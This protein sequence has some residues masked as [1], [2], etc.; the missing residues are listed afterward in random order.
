MRRMALA[1]T[2]LLGLATAAAAQITITAPPAGTTTVGPAD[3]YATRAFQDPWDMNEYTDLGWLTLG[4]DQ[5]AAN[6]SNISVSGGVFSANPT[7]G[8]P[9]FWLLDTF[10]PG[11]A[12]LGKVGRNFPIDASK[13]RD[14]RD[15]DAAREPAGSNV[16]AFGDADPLEQQHDLRH[17]AERRPADEQCGSHLRRRDGQSRRL[18][19]LRHR[20]RRRSAPRPDPA[21]RGA[22]TRC[23]STRPS[24]RTRARSSWTGRASC[25][26]TTRTSSGRSSGPAPPRWTSSSTTTRTRPTATWARSPAGPLAALSPSTWAG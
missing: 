7:N 24:T 5:P 26:S 18:E 13:Y 6:L 14:A 25:R 23:G 8:D 20:P 1:M 10:I 12:A 15:A 4:N 22:S 17:G 3:D 19:H 16:G 21:G 9:N 2:V 11:S